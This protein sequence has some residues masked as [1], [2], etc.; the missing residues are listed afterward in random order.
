MPE[1]PWSLN[2]LPMKVAISPLSAATSLTADLSRKALSAAVSAS[3]WCWLI[4]YCEFMN[5]W[6]TAKAPSPIAARSSVSLRTIP[7]GSTC[8][9][10]V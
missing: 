4:S 10:T 7:P 1:P 6:L 9:P 3:A 2:G 5:S 8:G